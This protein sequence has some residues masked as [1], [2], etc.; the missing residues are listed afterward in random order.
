MTLYRNVKEGA[1]WEVPQGG[2]SDCILRAQACCRHGNLVVVVGGNGVDRGCIGV[3]YKSGARPEPYTY[4]GPWY[5]GPWPAYD[6]LIPPINPSDVLIA[7]QPKAATG[8]IYERNVPDY[9]TSK[10]NLA[11]PGT[12]DAVEGVAPNWSAATG[13]TGTGTQYLDTTLIPA[14]TQAQ[15]MFI[16][17]NNAVLTDYTAACGALGLPATR[18]FGI[19]P[20][21]IPAGANAAFGN[22][23]AIISSIGAVSSGVNGFSGT[24]AYINGAPFLTIGAFWGPAA[25]SVH[26][27]DTHSA[28]GPFP[29]EME[30]PAFVWYST[31]ITDDQARAVSWAMNVIRTA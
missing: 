11:N 3:G 28:F 16:A 6:P 24:Q 20:G 9:A 12:Y 22:C 19:L 26:I 21:Y 14:A 1:N 4:R 17:Y 15:A 18:V 7:Y 23:S 27:F 25:F 8:T 5:L 31:T 13:W 2:Y 29:G 30:I 10:I